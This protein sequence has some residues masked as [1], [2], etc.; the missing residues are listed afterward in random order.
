[1]D[2]YSNWVPLNIREG[3]SDESIKTSIKRLIDQGPAAI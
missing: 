1:M 2:T 3:D